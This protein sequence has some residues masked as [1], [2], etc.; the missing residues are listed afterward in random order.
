MGILCETVGFQSKVQV[1]RKKIQF[2]K[3]FNLQKTYGK[4]SSRNLEI[5]RKEKTIEIAM[6]IFYIF[7]RIAFTLYY[8]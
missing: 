8:L 3:C 6:D 1:L 7:K 2:Y 5:R 4:K